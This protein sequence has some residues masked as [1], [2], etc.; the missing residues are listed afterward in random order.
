MRKVI[1][2]EEEYEDPNYF[3]TEEEAS[4]YNSNSGMN[5]AQIKLTEMALELAEIDLDKNIEILD[6]GCGTGF[7]MEYLKSLGY[8]NID[9][10]D[11]SREMVKIAKQKKLNVRIGGF[12]DL[13]RISKKYGLIISISALQWVMANKEGL[14]LKNII[15]KIGKQLFRLL[16]QE[17]S[18]VI[19]FYPQSKNEFEDVYS[20]FSRCDF[21]VKKV[22]ISKESVKKRR[23][24]LILRKKA[25]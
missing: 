22:I 20:A 1:T 6:I 3:Y 5:R 13:R 21:Y 9:G 8:R 19:Q 17:G 4:R 2:P 11:P 18:C 7:S 16:K 12:E 23:F 15:K 10:I 24:F 14:E 25:M